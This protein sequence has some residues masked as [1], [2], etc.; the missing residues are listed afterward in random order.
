MQEKLLRVEVKVLM[1]FAISAKERNA[2]YRNTKR[3]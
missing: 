1:D 3:V 2:C